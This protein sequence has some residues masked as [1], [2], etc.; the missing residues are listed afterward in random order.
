[1]KIS[2]SLRT[3][4]FGNTLRTGERLVRNGNRLYYR[5][6]KNIGKNRAVIHRKTLNLL[7][8]EEEKQFGIPF[9]PAEHDINLNKPDEENVMEN[10]S[11]T[12]KEAEN[13]PEVFESEQFGEIRVVQKD[14]EP[15]F[16]AT[17]V[18]RALEISNTGNAISRLDDDE[19]VT[20]HSTDS[21]SGQLGG[22]Q[23][24]T[25]VS[26]SGLYSLVLGSRK[27]EAK[28]FK[29][30][31]THEVIPS[32]R[33]TGGYVNDSSVFIDSYFPN[34]P[35][36]AR[37]MLKTALDESLKAQRMISVMKP[38]ADYCDKV[39]T[40]ENGY[41][42]TQIAK[43]YG[44]SAM[45]FNKILKDFRIQFKQRGQW[46]LYAPYAKQGYT[47][48]YTYPAKK[49][50][51]AATTTVWTQAGRAFLYEFLKNR[52]ITPVSIPAAV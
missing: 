36:A 24:M 27:P 14:G 22:A 46:L 20:I 8:R 25:I 44:M 13:T 51:Y 15:W 48:T 11:L 34:I 4:G 42:V 28:A 3:D 43:E 9:E 32:I 23:M 31:I 18:C 39:L 40:C 47:D 33:K 17:D 7:R 2:D 37:L 5:Y 29:R 12:I 6:E 50:K 38:K 10:T 26:E 19:K 45:A 52:G 35:E 21:H 30:W 41:T 16:M 49:G 1:M